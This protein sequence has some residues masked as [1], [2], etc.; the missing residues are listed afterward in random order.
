[1]ANENY[2]EKLPFLYDEFKEG[3]VQGYKD[4]FD[5]LEKTPAFWEMVKQRF[6]SRIRA[7]GSLFA[8]LRFSGGSTKTCTGRPLTGTSSGCNPCWPPKG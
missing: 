2:L 1:M 5:L 4:E 8:I 7:R 6:V 3:G